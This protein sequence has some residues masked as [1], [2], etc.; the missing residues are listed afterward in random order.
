LDQLRAL[1]A[2][3]VAMEHD[4]L[5]LRV[6]DFKLDIGLQNEIVRIFLE[7]VDLLAHRIGKWNRKLRAKR[8]LQTERIDDSLQTGGLA[9]CIRRLDD[10]EAS[11][12]RYV[13]AVGT[14]RREGAQA[15]VP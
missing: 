1:V 11:L 3:Y 2:D 8:P 10:I 15:K 4:D 7:L 5:A 14:R 9:G 6:G 12:E 13:G